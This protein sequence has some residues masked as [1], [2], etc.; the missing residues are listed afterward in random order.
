[1]SLLNYMV[2]DIL[3]FFESLHVLLAPFLIFFL[4]PMI[5]CIMS[6][7]VFLYH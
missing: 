1:M 5:L 6:S 7:M 4:R 3:P 2:S